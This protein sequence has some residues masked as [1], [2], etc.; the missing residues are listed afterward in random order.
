MIARIA[1]PSLALLA[2][3]ALAPAAR[4]DG[5]PPVKTDARRNAALLEAFGDLAR[6]V[7][8]SVATIAT[9]AGDEVG[10]GTAIGD[11][12]LILTSKTILEGAPEVLVVRSASGGSAQAVVLARNDAYDVALVKLRGGLDLAPLPLGSSRG[13]AAGDW[14]VTCGP[15][16]RPL[17]VGVVSALERRVEPRPE[18]RGALDLFGIMNENSGPTR[19]YARVIQHDSPLDASRAGGAPL[20]DKEGRLVGINVATAYRG[21]AYAAPIDDVKT[22]LEDMKAG[23]PGPEMPRPGYL[24]VALA[25]PRDAAAARAR[26]AR[27]PGVEIRQV[28]PGE[29]A[30]KAGLRAGDIVL[31]IDGEAAGSPERLSQLVRSK[32]P[33]ATV[34]V[35]VL[36][37]G[38]EVDVPVTLGARPAE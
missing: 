6:K 35:R 2:A 37:E 27:G 24:G 26:G 7:A 11:G 15:A 9:P 19:A 38:T 31:A 17:A 23:R 16:P 30:A 14:V 3:L 29:A 1:A 18:A 28:L 4:A 20:V 5:P 36:R 8:P 10:L 12:T 21:S 13:L 32:D 33:G 34:R 22:F 25:P